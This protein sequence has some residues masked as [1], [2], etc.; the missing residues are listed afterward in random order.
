MYIYLLIGYTKQLYIFHLLDTVDLA[1]L[2]QSTRL[3]KVFF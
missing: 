1:Q 2:D 3:K